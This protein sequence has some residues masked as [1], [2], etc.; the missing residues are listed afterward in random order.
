M[1]LTSLYQALSDL[2]GTLKDKIVEAYNDSLQMALVCECCMMP[3][4]VDSV[5]PI[6]IS[7]PKKSLGGPALV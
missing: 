3:Q 6:T 2:A 5:Y 1:R 4:L 7:E